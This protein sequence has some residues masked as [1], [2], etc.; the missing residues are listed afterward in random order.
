M[1]RI[2]EAIAEFGALVTEGPATDGGAS[3]EKRY[4]NRKR[5]EMTELREWNMPQ[6]HRGAEQWTIG[7]QKSTFKL[8]GFFAECEPVLV[9]K[10][11]NYGWVD[12]YKVGRG[13]WITGWVQQSHIL[14]LS[15]FLLHF[16]LCPRL[17]FFTH[18]PHCIPLIYFL[19]LTSFDFPL[20]IVLFSDSLFHPFVIPQFFFSCFIDLTSNHSL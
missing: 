19:T 12:Q 5:V 20:S 6:W 2:R 8:F 14:P 15:H 17:H 1:V 13:H 11:A 16:K 3:A 9:S 4:K 7:K 10:N 18:S